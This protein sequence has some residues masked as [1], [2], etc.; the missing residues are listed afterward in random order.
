MLLSAPLGRATRPVDLNRLWFD[1]KG[2]L[3]S[4]SAEL[5]SEMIS[6]HVLARFAP[7]EIM[8]RMRNG[9]FKI[10]EQPTHG[11]LL[12]YLKDMFTS[13]RDG[14]NNRSFQQRSRLVFPL[15]ACL[16]LPRFSVA[17]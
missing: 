8:T 3:G 12:A 14:L 15:A 5:F 6:S 2:D 9:A 10:F 11:V 16:A 17:A 1:V 7:N 4:H 13:T